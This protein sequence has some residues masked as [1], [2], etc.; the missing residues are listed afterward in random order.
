LARAAVNAGYRIIVAAGGDGTVH[1]VA[2]GILTAAEPE[3]TL[4]V[5]PIG[6]ANDYA[7]SL[8]LN[9]PAEFKPGTADA[10]RVDVG[11]VRADNG[12]QRFFINSL[13]LGFSSA[14]TV[15]A[16]Q[17]RRLQGLP[18]YVL[19]FLRALLFR[20]TCADMEISFDGQSRN[21]PTFS[22]TVAIGR[23]EGNLILTPDAIPDDGMF[24]YL[25]AGAL[26]RTEILRRLPTIVTGGK[27]PEDHP[28]LW[29]GRCRDVQLKSA[30]P[31]CIHLDGE[32]FVMPKDGVRSLAIRLLPR[33][34]RVH[35][36]SPSV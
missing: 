12:R 23:R 32:L 4:G 19:A 1:E 6:S 3:I 29:T 15:E 22:L 18:L 7:F 31:L 11:V 26:S 35:C 24:D 27:L 20:F 13:G 30:T 5:L 28:A 8:G 10:R 36:S 33:R 14:V 17:I 9:S 16:R 34:L 21:V 25:H 2:N